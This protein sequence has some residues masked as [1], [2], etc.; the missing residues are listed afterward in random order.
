MIAPLELHKAIEAAGI[1][2]A[3]VSVNKEGTDAVVHF[4]G[5]TKQQEAAA[6]AIVDAFKTAKPRR[7]RDLATLV[8]AVNALSAQDKAKLQAVVLAKFLQENPAA[9]RAVAVAIDGDEEVG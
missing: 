2:I 7:A 3:G 6:Q 1:P 9:A 4:N 8:T 5:A